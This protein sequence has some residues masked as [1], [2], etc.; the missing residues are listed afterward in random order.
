MKSRSLRYLREAAFVEIDEVTHCENVASIGDAV[1]LFPFLQSWTERV[2]PSEFRYESIPDKEVTL[3]RLPA[4]LKTPLKDFFV[5]P[6][7]AGALAQ[8]VIVNAQEIAASAIKRSRRTEILVIILVQLAAGILPDFV[9]HAREIHH[10]ARHF[11]R[12]FWIS[13]HARVIAVPAYLRNYRGLA[14]LLRA[15]ICQRQYPRPFC[16]VLE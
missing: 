13:R 4:A 11:P 16:T 1:L 3:I 10:A 9:Q 15:A 5:S 14:R 8:I 7:L 2:A 6:A 12:A